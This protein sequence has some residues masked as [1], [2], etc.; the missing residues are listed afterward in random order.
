MGALVAQ[1]YSDDVRYTEREQELLQ[2][3]STQ[4]AS[5]IE[6]KRVYDRLQY[7]ALHDHLTDLPNRALFQDR[8]KTALARARRDNTRLALLY[9]DMVRFKEV[10]DTYGHT[11]GD[12]LL[13][14]VALRLK[15]CVREVDT[16]GRIG[17]D[18]F[19]V[20]LDG[21]AARTDAALVA[22]KIFAV[23]SMPYELAGEILQVVPSIGIAVYPEDGEDDMQL[24]RHADD[25]MYRAKRCVK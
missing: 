14:E 8:L 15:Q 2:F 7:M 21:I 19:I 6:R 13:R 12:C 22:D 10:N 20:L 16:P 24:I 23:L 11:L 3:V 18:E 17:G 1:S 4:V 5:A 25:A 9:L